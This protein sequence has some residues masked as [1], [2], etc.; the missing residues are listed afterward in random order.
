M[1]YL[2][3]LDSLVNS[4]LSSFSTQSVLAAPLSMG[5]TRIQAAAKAIPLLMEPFKFTTLPPE[6][7]MRLPLLKLDYVHLFSHY[8]FTYQMTLD[9][10]RG[11]GVASS[12]PDFAAENTTLDLARQLQVAQTCSNVERN[13]A[14]YYATPMTQAS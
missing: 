3:P 2:E 4:L 11:L 5:P 6:N 12:C 7:I 8:Q 13:S 1:E 14:V 9:V 10:F